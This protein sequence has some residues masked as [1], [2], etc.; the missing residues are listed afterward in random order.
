MLQMHAEFQIEQ[1]P[2]ILN[3]KERLQLS[4]KKLH[5][6]VNVPV[7]NR[8]CDKFSWIIINMLFLP[9]LNQ[10]HESALFTVLLLYLKFMSC[11]ITTC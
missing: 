1:V 6:F 5:N 10:Y 8:Y 2:N 9:N 3:A 11:N 4:R 7:W